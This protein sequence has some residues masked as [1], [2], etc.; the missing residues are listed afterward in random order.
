MRLDVL[1]IYGGPVNGARRGLDCTATA[2]GVHRRWH[3]PHRRRVGFPVDL[4][5]PEDD[6]PEGGEASVIGSV[7]T[8]PRRGRAACQP[9]TAAGRQAGD[10]PNIRSAAGACPRDT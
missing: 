9:R 4:S 8:D 7:A 2:S 10:R 3:L 6:A 5:S 1:V